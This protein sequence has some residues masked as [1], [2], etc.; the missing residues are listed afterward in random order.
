MGIRQPFGRQIQTQH[1]HSPPSPIKQLYSSLG[2]TIKHRM[3]GEFRAGRLIRVTALPAPLYPGPRE[4][5]RARGSGLGQPTAATD[6][7]RSHALTAG[8]LSP[9]CALATSGG[10]AVLSLVP[11]A[12][13]GAAGQPDL[14]P[15]WALRQAGPEPGH[16]SSAVREAVR[17]A[18]TVV[19]ADR[20]AGSGRPSGRDPRSGPDS[21]RR[22]VWDRRTVA[23]RTGDQAQAVGPRGGPRGAVRVRPGSARR[24]TDDRS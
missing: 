15:D 7:R 22:A 24:S 20:P 6:A 17:P 21:R 19:P 4:P 11:G 16:R 3:K 13:P 5:A 2:S 9:S 18:R 8:T 10:R 12:V 23:A 14:P 1:N